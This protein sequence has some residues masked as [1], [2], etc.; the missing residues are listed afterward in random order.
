[1]NEQKY[2]STDVTPDNNYMLCYKKN[3]AAIF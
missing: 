2:Y 3:N 1:M